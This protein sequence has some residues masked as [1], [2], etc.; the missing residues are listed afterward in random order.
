MEDAPIT[1]RFIFTTGEYGR[2]MHAWWRHSWV[3]WFILAVVVFLLYSELSEDLASTKPMTIL[4]ITFDV[5]PLLFLCIFIMFLLY[6]TFRRSA[7]YQK[8]ITYT[9]REGGVHVHSPLAETELKWEIYPRATESRYG[10]ALFQLGKRS[11]HWIPKKAFV[12]QGDMARCRELIRKKV[13]DTKNLLP[14][15]R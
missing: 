5:I 2:A 8:E 3:K 15:N 9:L 1:C 10:F 14:Q 4:S 6:L 12:N 11:F 7:Y 13:K